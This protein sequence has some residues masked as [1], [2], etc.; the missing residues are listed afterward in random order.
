MKNIARLSVAAVILALGMILSSALLSKLFVSIK[1]EKE[2]SVKGYAERDVVSDVGTFYCSYSTRK[3][4][5]VDA[6]KELQ[7]HKRVVVN[8]LKNRGITD[9]QMSIREIDTKKIYKKDVEGNNTNEIQYYEATQGIR[10]TLEH[11]M[12]VRD[13]S[14]KITDLIKDG[15]DIYACSPEFYVSNLHEIKLELLAEATEDGYMRAVTLAENSGGAVG[16]LRS[17]RQ[18]VFQITQP[19]S[20]ETSGYGMYDTL[21]IHKTVKA[22]VTLEYSIVK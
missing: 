10:I 6:Y 4:T 22:V 3:P 14:R 9:G 12:L 16:P 11:V 19:Y 7:T 20:T 8:Y 15:I 13:I 21:T 2:I 1:H 5:L 17:A 18:G